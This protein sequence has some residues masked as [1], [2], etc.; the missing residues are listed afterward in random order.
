MNHNDNIDHNDITNHNTDQNHINHNT[1]HNA[2]ALTFRQRDWIMNFSK[3]WGL[4]WW[5][6]QLSGC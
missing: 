1:N 6:E 3:F 2:N 4:A 5:Q